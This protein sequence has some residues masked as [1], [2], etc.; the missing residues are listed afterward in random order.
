MYFLAG[1]KDSSATRNT[2]YKCILKKEIG[3]SS[4]FQL[5]SF[6]KSKKT[7][8]IINTTNSVVIKNL[9]NSCAL[10]FDPVNTVDKNHRSSRLPEDPLRPEVCHRD[11][12]CKLHSSFYSTDVTMGWSFGKFL[13]N[14]PLGFKSINFS[15]GGSPIRGLDLIFL[16]HPELQ[17]ELCAD[18]IYH[19]DAP[20]VYFRQYNGNNPNEANSLNSLW[21]I[22]HLGQENQGAIFHSMHNNE[23]VLANALTTDSFRLRNF[24]TG[25]VMIAK[26]VE[27]SHIESHIYLKREVP[28]ERSPDGPGRNVPNI[29]ESFQEEI[30]K[31]LDS[32][33]DLSAG[34]VGG[35]EQS[36]SEGDG[37]NKPSEYL[38]QKFNFEFVIVEEQ[39]LRN[40]CLVY[41]QT[42]GKGDLHRQLS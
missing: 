2:G 34:S 1:E 24:L 27:R 9:F 31:P 29:T 36:R 5:N 21:Q 12:H 33:H 39:Y 25:R 35:L 7:G 20:E 40:K 41:L 4:V 32:H 15:K 14:Q 30:E 37:A 8:D 16:N 11:P 18:V 23:D 6:Y 38:T 3:L 10:S 22:E 28:Q 17:G 19:L 13:K 42:H 26:F